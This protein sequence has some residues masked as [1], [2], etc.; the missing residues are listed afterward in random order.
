MIALVRGPMS[1]DSLSGSTV[2]VGSSTSQKTTSAPVTVI[3]WVAGGHCPVGGL[4]DLRAEVRQPH[5]QRLHYGGR[6]QTFSSQI[7]RQ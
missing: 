4:A 7:S 2:R 3:A 5:G 1:S 6:H